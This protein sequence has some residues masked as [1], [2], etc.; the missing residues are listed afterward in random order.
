MK[1]QEKQSVLPDWLLEKGYVDVHG[2]AVLKSDIARWA[3][4]ASSGFC[5][6]WQKFANQPIAYFAVEDVEEFARQIS[7]K[8]KRRRVP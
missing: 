5:K 1:K 8:T 3:N 2:E 7:Q 4:D 6:M